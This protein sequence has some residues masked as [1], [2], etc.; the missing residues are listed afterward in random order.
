MTNQEILDEF[1]SLPIEAQ[2]QV[3]S[4]ITFLK[5]KYLCSDSLPT[6]SSVDLVSDPF[7]GMWR[8]REDLSSTTWL[9]NLRESEW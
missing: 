5:Q 9:R 3:V 6:S 7:V 4:L 8:D 1:L 2:K